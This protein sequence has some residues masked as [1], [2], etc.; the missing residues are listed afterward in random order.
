MVLVLAGSG[1]AQDDP[2][3]SGA[4]PAAAVETSPAPGDPKTPPAAPESAEADRPSSESAQASVIP[5]TE[6][7][8]KLANHYLRLLEQKPEYGNVLELLWG[9]YD[10]KGQTSLLLEYL[11][12]VA[13]AP[14]APPLPKLIYAHLLR[15]NEQLDEAR[16]FYGQVLDAEPDNLVALRASAEISDQQ[17]RT[18]K[19]LSQYTRLAQLTAIDTEDGATFRMRQAALLKQS[20]QLD[21][22]VGIWNALLAAWPRH[23]SLR[24]EI[25]SMLIEA[26]R[27][28]DAIGAL[29]QIVAS[30]D[31]EQRLASLKSLNRL[32]E[33]ISD[34]NGAAGALDEA[35]NLVHFKHHEFADLFTR[36]VR[37]YERFDKLPELESRLETE[38]ARPNPSEKAVFLMAEYYRLTAAP[39]KE[40]TWVGKLAALVPGNVDYR[41]R[42]VETQLRNDHYA[43]AAK[44]L[45]ALIAS[46][47]E[48]PLRL[49]L[50]RSRVAL[51]MEGKSAAEARLEEFLARP[52]GGTPQALKQVLAFSQEHY[53]DALVE[54]LLR[55]PDA[56]EITGAE[57]AAAPVELARFFRERG[58]DAQ[59]EKALRDYVDEA[60]QS[61][62]LRAARLNEVASAFRDL[63][64]EEKALGAIDEAIGLQPE[65]V[66]YRMARAEILVDRKRFDEAVAAFEEIW[67]K[68]DSLKAQSEIDQR[69]FSLLRGQVDESN[70]GGAFASPANA[71]P[72]GRITSLDQ[73]RR[74]AAA[75]SFGARE[76]DEPPPQKLLD[77]YNTIKRV[78]N[79]TKSLKA[80]YRAAWWSFKLQDFKE[81]Y[82]HLT[83]AQAEA[84]EKPVFEI[85]KMLFDLAEQN[86]RLPFMA[87]HLETLEKI[88][89]ENAREYRQ[90]W[91]E[92]RFE[93]GYEDE[94]IRLLE[95]LARDPEASLNTLKTLASVYERQG[96]AESQIRV[97]QDAYRRA[98]LF[99]KRR[100]IKQLATT[101][102][103]LGR[104]EQ[105]LRSQLDL[106]RHETDLEQ[107]RKQFDAQLSTA[108]RHYL[109]AWLRDRYL[110]LA[111]QQ[112]FERFFPEA[113]AKIYQANGEDEAAFA[114]M[115]RAYYMS[116][117][118]RDLLAELGEMASRTKDLKSAIYYHRQLIAQNEDGAS[119]DGWRDLISML[120]KDLRVE[121]AD[122]IRRRLESKFTQDPDFL[123]QLAKQYVRDGQSEDAERVLAKLTTLRPWD[124]AAWLEL[125][126][127][128]GQRGD[129]EGA[130]AA[131]DRVIE[132]AADEA[133]RDAK[134]ATWALAPVFRGGR[135]P[136]AGGHRP[137]GD[138]LE[139]AVETIENYPYLDHEVTRTITNWLGGARP[140]FER[141]PSKPREI[142]LRAIEER[143]KLAAIDPDSAARQAW[144]DRWKSD[145]KAGVA[146]KLWALRHAG[147][148]DEAFELAAREMPAPKSALD[149]FLYSLH[150]LRLGRA[151][152]LA[153]W[154]GDPNET[155][156]ALKADRRI[157]RVLASLCLLRGP[158][159]ED[160]DPETAASV[161]RGTAFTE[162]VAWHYFNSVRDSGNTE[163]TFRLGE[164]LAEGPL[165]DDGD[166]RYD[167]SLLAKDLGQGE[168]RLFHLEAALANMMP[169][170]RGLPRMYHA[171]LT[172]RIAMLPTPAEKDAFVAER[173]A[174]VDA[175]P[176][177]TPLVR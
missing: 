64:L 43:E 135:A 105:A 90:R 53:L 169:D 158:R 71:P 124:H 58:R 142:R 78:S 9:L 145:A 66:D 10:K 74:L 15:K 170:R 110:E 130:V 116:G 67:Q 97:W 168:R 4:T 156:A 133:A 176:E 12:G 128:R 46:Q 60:G 107:K 163:S 3:K 129:R 159:D 144:I 127:I 104:P 120:E 91:A 57:G 29:R 100:I 109:L 103:E 44:E 76:A 173:I 70:T 125:G 11:S 6:A 80:R 108:S 123:K 19:A 143:A 51:S 56:A 113:L 14:E 175:H 174:A 81:T 92:I 68:T 61:D 26:G 1:I 177:S 152:R 39:Q 31:P 28:E 87:R 63:D 106:I 95:D 155:D 115:K 132:N 93:L 88:D 49:V 47:P 22:A 38:A 166:F 85:E 154:V 5:W 2:V 45:D 17:Q 35:M 98:S 37:L 75:A 21:E 23:P 136:S 137:D 121:E 111:Q 48:S 131:F 25:V 161:F 18:A 157:M 139:S 73:Y 86:G 162:Q 146:E 54:R 102:I 112:P 83:Q 55:R 148:S 72:S 32:H 84:G 151:D 172:E 117:Q 134:G 101:L 147:A 42:L 20:G 126:L 94:A 69:L 62:T 99:E 167:L 96:R 153:A 149:R 33:F 24:T 16:D 89:P 30:E 13:K 140:E 118:D 40:E 34:F 50:L 27:T 119:V 65:N 138:P 141:I 114:A 165:K 150:C 77:F 164:A 79:D 36:L 7:D 8:T 52:E 82:H 122:L 160:F 171:A 59:A 41:V